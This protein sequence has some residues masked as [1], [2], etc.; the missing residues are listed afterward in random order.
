M[1]D[2][3]FAVSSGGRRYGPLQLG[4]ALE[5][6]R[7]GQNIDYHGASGSVDFDERG[8]V[9]ANYIVWKVEGAEF[10]PV[11]RIRASELGVP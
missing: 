3:L 6:V 4:E 11:E 2:A 1:R 10:K 7:N 5:A 9:V 8:D